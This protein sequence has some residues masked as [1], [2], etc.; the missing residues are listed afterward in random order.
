MLRNVLDDFLGRA[1][2]R[3]LDLPLLALLP[4]IGFHDVHLI[5][6]SVE[7]GKDFIAKRAE[8]GVGVQYV[9]Q[10][11]AGDINHAEWRRIE[12]QIIE[13]AI[14]TLGHPNFDATLPR[15]TVLIT[16]G[17]LSGNARLGLQNL[18]DGLMKRI[19]ASPVIYWIGRTSSNSC[20]NSA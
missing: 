5:H 17:D 3:E 1:N 6:G 8:D 11:K 14:N 7:F 15:Q 18:N 20:W 12:P 19:C 4:A 16:S 9:F 2:E 10:S 13:A